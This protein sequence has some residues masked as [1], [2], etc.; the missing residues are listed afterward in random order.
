M[1]FWDPILIDKRLQNIRKLRL[2]IFFVYLLLVEKKQDG[3]QPHF[4]V[5]D[6]FTAKRMS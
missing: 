3:D 5:M 2:I 1:T 6:W 4:G